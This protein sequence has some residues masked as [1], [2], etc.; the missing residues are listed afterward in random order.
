MS[1]SGPFRAGGT[2]GRIAQPT[3]AGEF[4]RRRVVSR[5]VNAHCPAD[6]RVVDLGAGPGHLRTALRPDLRARYT[7]VD[8]GSG[9]HGLR[10]AG[11]VT[12]V[13]LASGAADV[14]CLSD[15]LEHLVRDRDA[16][17][18]A[19]RVAR[20]GGRIIVHV[21][22]MRTKPYAFLQRAA[23]EAEAA[24]HQQFPHVRD[25]YSRPTLEE[26]F[27][28]VPDSDVVLIGASFTAAQSLLSD[29]DGYLWWRRWTVL[30]AGSWLAI[31]LASLAGGKP[32]DGA[33]SS[34]YLAVLQR[35][36]ASDRRVQAASGR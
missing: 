36:D 21:P 13:P 9:P 7:V 18:E 26:L 12:V 29:V 5:Y 14:V 22:S 33:T 19:V 6:G 15:V 17:L 27:A 8:V 23:D 20:P 1:W 16:V 35:R 30:R 28:E 24:D 10:I 32:R 11:D 31:R 3:G 25:G 2:I 4:V 34:G